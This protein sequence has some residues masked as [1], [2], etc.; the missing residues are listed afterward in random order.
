MNANGAT[1]NLFTL[2]HT[3][4]QFILMPPC[5]AVVAAV[6]A[7]TEASAGISHRIAIPVCMVDGELWFDRKAN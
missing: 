7:A 6:A 1:L 2:A 3:T 5:A 4:K